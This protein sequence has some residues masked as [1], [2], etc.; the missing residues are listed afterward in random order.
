SL[1]LSPHKRHD[2]VGHITQLVKL[3]LTHLPILKHILNHLLWV[4]LN[5]LSEL[6]KLVHK[7]HS[8]AKWTKY[9]IVSA[10]TK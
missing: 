4:A 2:L 8:A 7:V 3:L 6:V 9:I 1:I 10:I 5:S